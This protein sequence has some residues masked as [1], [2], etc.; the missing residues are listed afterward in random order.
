MSNPFLIDGNIDGRA[1]LNQVTLGGDMKSGESITAIDLLASEYLVNIVRRNKNL[2]IPKGTLDRQIPLLLNTWIYSK[3]KGIRKAA[4]NIIATYIDNILLLL[5]TIRSTNQSIR[6]RRDNWKT[7]D[8]DYWLNNQSYIFTGGLMAGVIGRRLKTK[9]TETFPDLN[10]TIPRHPQLCPLIGASLILNI[11]NGNIMAFDFGQSFIKRAILTVKNN[12]IVSVRVFSSISTERSNSIFNF[13][14]SNQKEAFNT[15]FYSAFDHSVQELYADIEPLD[16]S[17]S[18]SF[19]N[20]VTQTGF[21]DRGVYGLL[22][23]EGYI[24]TELLKTRLNN[25][26]IFPKEIVMSHDGT[27]AAR[28]FSNQYP[29]ACITFGSAL[30]LGFVP[31]LEN[32]LKI[33]LQSIK[34]PG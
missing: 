28:C 19:A 15:F 26:G 32:N 11:S 16:F 5:K 22:N 21:A 12:T 27:A 24:F 20:Y 6:I 3:N 10:C 23:K 34:I 17:I 2:I 9:I 1:S 8:W 7:E 18:C 25:C 4:S 33:D 13:K 30:G 14:V 29:A 31:K